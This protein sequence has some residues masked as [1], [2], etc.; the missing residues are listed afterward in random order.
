MTIEINALID[1][2]YAVEI[3]SKISENQKSVTDYIEILNQCQD[4]K[5][6]IFS[7]SDIYK[8][9]SPT[10]VDPSDIFFS[11]E[12]ISGTFRDEIFNFVKAVDQSNTFDPCQY[13]NEDHSDCT[14]DTHYF[15]SKNTHCGVLTNK[16]YSTYTWWKQE[17]H[18]AISFNYPP[19]I[20]LRSRISFPDIN[21]K[22]FWG[23]ANQT[24]P[25][26]YFHENAGGFKFSK[27]GFT[28]RDSQSWV[29]SVFSYLND[30]AKSDFSLPPSEIIGRA[31]ASN[32]TISPDS[33]NTHNSPKDMKLRS[34]T[35]GNEK[36]TCEW[37]AKFKHNKG[38]IHFHIGQ[39]LSD[40]ITKETGSKIIIGIFCEHL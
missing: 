18:K 8:K 15:L 40:S 32:I 19:I 36:I 38:R 29:L 37:H 3:F 28:F 7:S 20:Y 14:E 25:N 22:Q 12:N 2:L 6:K 13:Y 24:F 4:Q 10:N 11:Q 23:A 26:L 35:I 5:F 39:N 1:D 31:S 16:N 9:K 33:P 34:I 30:H 27:L 17:T 21:E